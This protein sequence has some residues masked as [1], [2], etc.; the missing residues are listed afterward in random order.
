MKKFAALL[1]A[2]LVVSLGLVGFTS[3]G[4][5]NAAGICPKAPYTG[6]V[7]TSIYATH[8]AKTVRVNKR[9]HRYALYTHVSVSAGNAAPKSAVKGTVTYVLKRYGRTV[10]TRHFTYR[11]NVGTRASLKT[12]AYRLSVIFTPKRGSVVKRS[13][14]TYRFTVK[15][16]LKKPVKKHAKR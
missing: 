16:A 9:S 8:P 13:G 15:N 14:A 2:A 6:C 12:G 1:L 4:A 11:K 7:R 10:F 5:S 3:S